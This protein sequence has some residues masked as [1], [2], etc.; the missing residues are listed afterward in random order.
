MLIG[1]GTYR[2]RQFLDLPAVRNNLDGLI[3]VL[4]DPELSGLPADHCV[5]LHD[6]TDVRTVYRV[7]RQYAKKAQDTLLVYFAG[8]GVPALTGNGLYLSLTDTDRDELRVSALSIDL[9]REIFA[10]CPA[11]NRVLILDCCFSGRAA[12]GLMSGVDDMFYGQVEI[13]G[14][15][16][17]TSAPANAA[18]I[19]PVGARYTAFTG[20]LLTLLR[21][22]IPDGPELL[23]LS[24][25]YRRLRYTLEASGLPVPGR[26][27]TDTADRLAL[28]RNAAATR[29]IRPDE[30]FEDA[31]QPATASSAP[32]EDRAIVIGLA[33]QPPANAAAADKRE[34]WIIGGIT[35]AVTGAVLGTVEAVQFWKALTASSVL[36]PPP[37]EPGSQ[38]MLTALV[39]VLICTAAIGLGAAA[40]AFGAAWR[41]VGPTAF[42]SPHRIELSSGV[43]LITVGALLLIFLAGISFVAKRWP[44]I[45]ELKGLLP[46]TPILIF[47]CTAPNDGVR[48][49][50]KY[51]RGYPRLVIDATGLTVAVAQSH[52]ISIEWKYIDDIEFTPV[53]KSLSMVVR[54]SFGPPPP[55]NPQARLWD[56]E[57]RAFVFPGFEPL[58]EQYADIS[59][60]ILRYSGVPLRGQHRPAPNS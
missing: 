53:A 59:A 6:P 60:A 58:R 39:W 24:T 18:A 11:V 8:H 45:N 40:T 55:E 27:V 17:L 52:W 44:S 4:T 20:E 33:E 2:D 26:Q 9:L 22:G 47:L 50:I 30:L 57:L 19:A 36:S 13:A 34:N 42:R 56:V 43:G 38:S 16:T 31:P 15:Y 32:A 5:A 7:L 46:F 12:K 3:E 21:T 35:T 10:Y 48:R 51:A 25:I 1:T 28:C 37:P 54:S 29:R 14:T 41:P 49:L 23:T